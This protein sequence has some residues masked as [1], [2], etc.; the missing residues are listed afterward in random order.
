MI[1]VT[2]VDF[3]IVNS[4]FWDG[5]VPCS[6]SYGVCISQLVRFARASSD[7][8]DFNTCNKLLIQK[9]TEQGYQYHKLSKSL[10]KFY[11]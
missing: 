10:P 9:F 1:N 6:T 4:P 2:I 11:Q 3:E 8:A 5:D 7:V